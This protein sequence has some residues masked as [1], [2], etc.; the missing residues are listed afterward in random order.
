MLKAGVGACPLL[1]E[2]SPSA[3]LGPRIRL[4]PQ[5]GTYS[6]LYLGKSADEAYRPLLSLKP[7]APYRDASCGVSTYHLTV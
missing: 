5:I 6:V 4:C 2:G 3:K 1:R 7:F